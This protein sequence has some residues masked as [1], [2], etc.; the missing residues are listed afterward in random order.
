MESLTKLRSEQGVNK[1]GDG[2]TLCHNDKQAHQ[3]H[4][5]DNGPQP[6]FFPEFKEIPE[7]C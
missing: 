7:F 2:A 6:P 3:Q 1:R 4:D 5:E